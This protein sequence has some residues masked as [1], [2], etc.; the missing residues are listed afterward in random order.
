MSKTSVYRIDNRSLSDNGDPTPA[1][2][3]ERANAVRFFKGLLRKARF[4]WNSPKA[5]FHAKGIRGKQV[6]PPI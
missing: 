4:L 5:N 2:S 3:L 1:E 6:G